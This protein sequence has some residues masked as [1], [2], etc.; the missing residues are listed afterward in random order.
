M[1]HKFISYEPGFMAMPSE[2][3]SERRS[4]LVFFSSKTMIIYPPVVHEKNLNFD[5]RNF[6]VSRY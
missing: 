3:R 2:A 6:I 4:S 1:I 5:F